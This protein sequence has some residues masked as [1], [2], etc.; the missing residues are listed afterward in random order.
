MTIEQKTKAKELIYEAMK[1]KKSHTWK[2]EG[3]KYYH[4]E[5]VASIAIKLRKY[6]FPDNDR[7]D[8]MLEVAAWYH[9]IHN[10][11][12]RHNQRGAE[13]AKKMLTGIIPDYDLDIVQSIIY[14]HDSR[15]P[16]A[17]P[18]YPFYVKLH[19]D[20]DLLD[21][22]GCF[23]IWTEMLHAAS[24]GVSVH[25]MIDYLNF[26]RVAICEA[27]IDH[28]NYDVSKEI[29]KEKTE[30]LKKFGDRFMQECTT[31]IY[32]EEQFFGKKFD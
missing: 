1:S 3:D 6:L 7:Y 27:E 20:A 23:D 8:D 28:F 24:M 31:G 19:Q 13:T 22:Y 2:E 32:N 12:E 14:V 17:D 5:R 26:A 25:Y 4:G 21:H 18:G 30:F 11:E 29:F 9:D 16:K 10:G 15:K